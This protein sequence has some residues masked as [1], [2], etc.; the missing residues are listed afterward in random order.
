MRLGDE[1]LQLVQLDVLV[2][3]VVRALIGGELDEVVGSLL[4]LEPLA[5]TL[6]GGKIPAV[7][8]SSAIMLQIVVRPVTSMLATPGP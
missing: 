1:R 6:V 7:A 3:V 5:G 8:P 4:H 2:L